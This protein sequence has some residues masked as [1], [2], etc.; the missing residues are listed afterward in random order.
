MQVAVGTLQALHDFGM[1]WVRH[2]FS[3][4]GS[5][6]EEPRYPPR[7]DGP[8]Q[9]DSAEFEAYLGNVVRGFPAMHCSNRTEDKWAVP[10]LVTPIR[11]QRGWR[12]HE[13]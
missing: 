12:R 5:P 9:L 11:E 6:G 1:T 13:T 8:K 2:G 3:N 4:W 7:E 10:P